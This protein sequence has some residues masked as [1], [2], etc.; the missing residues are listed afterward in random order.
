MA[1]DLLDD[2]LLTPQGSFSSQNVRNNTSRR[3]QLKT[4]C[5]IYLAILGLEVVMLVLNASASAEMVN[6]YD[7][8]FLSLEVYD[9]WTYIAAPIVNMISGLF[10]FVFLIMT[11]LWMRRAY[12]NLHEI[13]MPHLK[14]S[15]GWAAGCWFVPIISF[16]VPFQIMRDIW[17][18]TQLVARGQSMVR[19]NS[20]VGWWWTFHLAPIGI[21]ILVAVAFVADPIDSFGSGISGAMLMQWIFEGLGILCV[22]GSTYILLSI[23]KVFDEVEVEMYEAVRV[24]APSAAQDLDGLSSDSPPSQP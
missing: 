21:A 13:N 1:E 6:S 22:A 14:W 15:E 12:W 5:T 2:S 23:L 20:L 11:I 3:N 7:D 24:P 18:K 19:D 4:M 17:S 9:S 10:G 8:D 16:F